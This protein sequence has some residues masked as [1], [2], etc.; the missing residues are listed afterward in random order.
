M[1]HSIQTFD[2][3][4]FRQN[5]KIWSKTVQITFVWNILQHFEKIFILYFE[6]LIKLLAQFWVGKKSK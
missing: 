3:K 2:F 4:N 5:Q 1:S 6:Y